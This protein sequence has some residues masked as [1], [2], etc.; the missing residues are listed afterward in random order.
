MGILLYTVFV[1]FESSVLA[2]INFGNFAIICLFI[3]NCALNLMKYNANK[4]MQ[5]KGYSI[6]YYYHHK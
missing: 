5:I 3:R 4:G 6:F 1:N 2:G